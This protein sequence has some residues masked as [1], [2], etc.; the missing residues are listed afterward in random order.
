MIRSQAPWSYK[1]PKLP[2]QKTVLISINLRTGITPNITSKIHVT[3]L[4]IFPIQLIDTKI[5]N[6]R[7][8][9]CELAFWVEGNVDIT[10]SDV[11][12]IG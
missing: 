10:T 6:G 1:T 5:R 8:K 3:Y 2:V 4:E 11:L 9:F 7:R 12:S